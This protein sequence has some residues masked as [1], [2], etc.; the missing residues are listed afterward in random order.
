[1]NE[2]GKPGEEL[3]LESMEQVSGGFGTFEHT[4]ELK[5]CDRCGADTPWAF[6]NGALRCTRCVKNP[7]VEAA[8]PQEISEP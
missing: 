8:G 7:F 4:T 3:D 5:Y 2:N 1:M 6:I